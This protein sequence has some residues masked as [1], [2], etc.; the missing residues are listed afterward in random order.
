MS[1]ISEVKPA[2]NRWQSIVFSVP[3]GIADVGDDDSDT[4]DKTVSEVHGTVN[5][6]A[7]DHWCTTA[8]DDEQSCSSEDA[9][10]WCMYPCG[11]SVYARKNV[12]LVGLVRTVSHCRSPDQDVRISSC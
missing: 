9:C 6:M 8:H 11:I 5:S 12:G 2:A 3:L 10:M 7:A 1:P 4:D